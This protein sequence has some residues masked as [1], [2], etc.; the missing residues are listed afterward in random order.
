MCTYALNLPLHPQP[1]VLRALPHLCPSLCLG[2]HTGIERP[3]R[4]SWALH[5]TLPS[6][7]RMRLG[8]RLFERATPLLRGAGELV[9]GHLAGRRAR[10]RGLWEF[11][12]VYSSS[13]P[14]CSILFGD[15]RGGHGLMMFVSC[16]SIKHVCLVTHRLN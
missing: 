16:V 8:A 10:V 4:L 15:G 5:P 1:R 2:T 9:E 13:H 12:L 7:L 11:L 14:T 6:G 3:Y